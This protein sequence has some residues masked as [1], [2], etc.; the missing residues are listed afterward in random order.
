MG[1]RLPASGALASEAVGASGTRI[2]FALE[3]P[4]LMGSILYTEQAPPRGYVT[5]NSSG[6]NPLEEEG[7]CCRD[8]TSPINERD[9]E[10]SSSS[11]SRGMRTPTPVQPA[12]QPGPGAPLCPSPLIPWAWCWDTA[13]PSSRGQAQGR[14]GQPWFL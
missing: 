14:R 4:G 3:F 11:S 12:A 6:E 10:S 13:Q 9:V 5:F 2:G 1:S 7:L 8:V